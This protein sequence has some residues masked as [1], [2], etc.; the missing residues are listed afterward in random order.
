MIRTEEIQTSE[1]LEALRPQWSA[2]WDACPAATPFQSPEWLIPWWQVFSPGRL[3]AIAVHEQGRLTGFAPLYLGEDRVLR[4]LGTGV[5]DYLD[6]LAEPGSAGA[7]TSALFEH[8]RRTAWAWDRC[9]LLELRE[10][11]PLLAAPAPGEFR[12]ETAECSVCPVAPLPASPGSNLRRNLRRYSQR[13][14]EAGAISY[15]VECCGRY[16]EYLE[17]LFRLHSACWQERRS[18]G[19]LSDARV[20]DF[21]RLVAAGFA[22]RSWLRMYGLRHAGSLAAVLY[23]FAARGRVYLYLSGFAPELAALSPGILLLAFALDHSAQAGF[24]EAD[25]LRGN[26]PYK[27]LWGASDRPNC[28]LTLHVS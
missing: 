11:S 14:A 9:D 19:V 20:R 23:G 24:I 28:R 4:F 17:A 7:A 12:T 16:G 21:H 18:P 2:L 15:E 13:L 3:T 26:E 6:L 25:F 10:G 5:T 1:E 8:L 27:Y 22:A